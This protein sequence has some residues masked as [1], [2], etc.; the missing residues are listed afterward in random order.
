MAIVVSIVTL[1]FMMGFFLGSELLIPIH[2][3]KYHSRAYIETYFKTHE[4]SH[5]TFEYL[6]GKNN[7]YSKN[8][9]VVFYDTNGKKFVDEETHYGEKMPHD[10]NHIAENV[11]SRKINFE[12]QTHRNK[13]IYKP[14]KDI[15]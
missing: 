2:K 9:H 1:F 4:L 7:K 5:I 12:A 13:L 10:V 11:L 6:H 3:R 8:Y 15:Q 14:T